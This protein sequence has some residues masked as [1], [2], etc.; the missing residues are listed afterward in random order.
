MVQLH[1]EYHQISTDHSGVFAHSSDVCNGVRKEDVGGEVE[2][3]ESTVGLLV[4]VGSQL[5]VK[6]G[7]AVGVWLRKMVGFVLGDTVVGG[8]LLGGIERSMLS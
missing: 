6:V 5:V 1:L 4:A 7:A 2:T 8:E 3:G